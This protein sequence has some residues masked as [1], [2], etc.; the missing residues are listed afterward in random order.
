MRVFAVITRL[1]LLATFVLPA[2]D[3]CAQPKPG[4]EPSS[5]HIFPA[6]GQRGTVVPVRVGAECIPPD[7]NF[8]FSGEGVSAGNILSQQVFS[9]AEESPRRVPTEIPITHPREWQSEIAIADDA[10][11]GT[12][13]WRLSCASGGTSSRPFLIGDLPEWIETESNSTVDRAER[14]ELPVTLNGQI[15]G[16]RDVDY[17]RFSA[18][19]DEV[20]VCELVAARI[21]SRLD[22]VIEVLDIEGHTIPSQ[23]IHRGSDPVIAF[24]SRKST[25]YLIRVSN[26]SWHGSPAHVYRINLTVRPFVHFA[27]PAGGQPG[28]TQQVNFFALSG[29]QEYNI[30]TSDVQF[31]TTSRG[32]LTVSDANLG[33]AGVNLTVDVSPNLLEQEPNDAGFPPMQTDVPITING[34]IQ[35]EMDE[36]WF[37]IAAKEGEQ[38]SIVGRSYPPG[39]PALLTV[40]V[41]DS[42]QKRLAQSRSV[43]S[44]DGVCRI[45]WQAPADGQYLVRAADMRHGAR[46]GQEF[47]YRLSIE[48]AQPD[49]SLSVDYDN[50]NVTQGAETKVEVRLIRI[51]GFDGPVELAMES[52]PE[53]V[54]LSDNVFK[55]GK[56]SVSLK[57]KVADDVGAAS[58]ASQLIG[59]ATIADQPV[60]RVATASHLG[61]DGQGVS[62]GSSHVEELHVT[63]MHKPLFRLQCSEHY[64]YAHRG[65]IYPYLMDVER[66]E[67]YD[68]PIM[69][70]QGDRQNRDMDGVQIF[71]SVVHPGEME[72]IVPIYLPETMHI[73]VQGQTQ[74]YTQGYVQ[75]VDKLGK[76]QSML[77][78]AEKRNMIRSMPQ[79]VKL[80]A[81]D[82]SIS[83][84]PGNSV[85]CRLALQ[86][87]SNFDGPMTVELV[88]RPNGIS[89]EPARFGAG[90]DDAVVEIHISGDASVNKGALLR[91]RATG[92]LYSDRRVISEV[93]VTLGGTE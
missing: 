14:V 81:I 43:E 4:K 60:E 38:F 24:R 55:P 8:W 17:Y 53:G 89:A 85:Q 29:G 49:F 5:T 11:V 2:S 15:N 75:F 13:Y 26:V 61:V 16:E 41:A 59:R 42:Q 44:R 20:V 57:V 90:E 7:S 79:I 92:L 32:L 71:D 9:I 50:V 76:P 83:V 21:G 51:G 66:F 6:G 31:P 10:V 12:A 65:T 68:G 3:A 67:D 80:Q 25:D 28:S 91:F 58:Y 23:T 34:A 36:D 1:L 78:L 27:F 33:I 86:R 54:S 18:P 93:T 88:E 19:A 73:N 30:L 22:G 77:F 82:E 37:R 69:L 47:I 56:D 64:Q 84:L 74:L 48:R 52:L 35:T 62:I 40:T 72:A 70:Q 87:T 39:G 46:G 45:E 63:V